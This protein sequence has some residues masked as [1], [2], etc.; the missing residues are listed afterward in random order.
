MFNTSNK[1]FDTKSR[2]LSLDVIRGIA[3]LGMIFINILVFVP[4]INEIT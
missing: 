3:V 4:N 2:N 1:L